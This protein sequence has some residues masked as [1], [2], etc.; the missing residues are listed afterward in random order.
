[1]SEQ[2]EKNEFSAVPD[3]EIKGVVEGLDNDESFDK[4][5]ATTENNSQEL[6]DIISS[7]KCT[8]VTIVLDA[9][10]SMSSY[11]DTV[12]KVFRDQL[13]PTVSK[14]SEVDSIMFNLITFDEKI[15]TSGFCHVSTIPYDQ[16]RA[17]GGTALYDAICYATRNHIAYLDNLKKQN[18][19]TRSVVIIMTDGDNNQ[20]I[21]A[22]QESAIKA[23]DRLKKVED[24]IVYIGFGADAVREANDLGIPQQQIHRVDAI[25]DQVIKNI[26]QIISKSII[27]TSSGA[28]GKK[29]DFLGE[30]DTNGNIKDN[31][32]LDAFSQN[33]GLSEDNNN[34]PFGI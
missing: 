25:N 8:L 32:S 6:D 1:M 30:I 12:I 26:F 31:N 24:Q 27:A 3:N 16:Y 34:N 23:I 33:N 14:S 22:T 5:T 7:D 15:S 2:N 11:S 18:Y 21:E 13:V 17:D 28:A 19:T 29:D 9:S 20:T 10:G 4:I